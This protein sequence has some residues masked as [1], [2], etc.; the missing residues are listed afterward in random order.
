MAYT[1]S[2]TYTYTIVDIE[3]VMR[4]FT[5]DLVMVAQ[6]SG[7]ITEARARD[8]AHDIES[9]AKEGYLRRVDVT[10]LSG[11]TELKATQYT[12][13]TAAGSLSMSRP[14][15][16]LWPRV[17]KAHLRI[18]LSY[19]D[20]YDAVAREAMRGRLKIIWVPTDAD[21][22]HAMLISTGGRDY[23]SNAW[24]MRRKDFAA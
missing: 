15:S 21:T 20:N 13:N 14:G 4:R 7:T 12:V 24:G 5:A 16:V 9:L 19:T 2:E 22:S 11:N 18:V 17:S 1:E 23:A 10:L 3:T 6:S 8:Y